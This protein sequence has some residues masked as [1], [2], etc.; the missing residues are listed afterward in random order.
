MNETRQRP[1]WVWIGRISDIEGVRSL[2]WNIASA[3][4]FGGTAW[5]IVKSLALA[6]IFGFTCFVVG[7]VVLSLLN[8]RRSRAEVCTFTEKPFSESYAALYVAWETARKNTE[9][10]GTADEQLASNQ[11]WPQIK[12]YAC[13]LFGHKEFSQTTWDCLRD[14]LL[15]YHVESSE[16]LHA[17]PQSEVLGHLRRSNNWLGRIVARH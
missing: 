8:K 2:M 15:T 13:T 11:A 1:Y 3:I 10:S 14:W 5:M 16:Q 4:S 9:N 12:R 6:A 7:L 17:M